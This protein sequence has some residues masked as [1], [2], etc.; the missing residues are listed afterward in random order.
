MRKDGNKKE[1]ALTDKKHVC[2]SQVEL[3]HFMMPEH[4]NLL[5]NVHGGIILKLVDEAGALCAMRHAQS[6]AVTVS[7]DSMSFLSPVKV[8]D[9][10]TM[11]ARLNYVGRTSMEVEV[12]VTAENPITGSNTHTNSAY[13]VYVALNDEGRPTAVPGLEYESDDERDR[14]AAASSRQKRRLEREALE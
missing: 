3:H 2:D 10:L 7:I 9:V 8:G 6:P 13:A 12:K 5:G 11:R 14:A 1:R 4:A